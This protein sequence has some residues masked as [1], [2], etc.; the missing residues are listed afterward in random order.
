MKLKLSINKNLNERIFENINPI[1]KNDFNNGETL[2]AFIDILF[3]IIFILVITLLSFKLGLISLFLSLIF[4][5]FII[6]K[7][8]LQVYLEKKLSNV[9]KDTK[10]ALNDVKSI[11]LT[12]RA[13]NAHEMLIDK[14]R[15]Y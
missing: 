12:V 13:F 3:I 15:L 6:L 11:P 14:F 8:K 4:T 2:I 1:E 5:L 10:S 9:T 7:S